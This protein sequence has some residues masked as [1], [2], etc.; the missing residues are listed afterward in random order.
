MYP[1]NNTQVEN[2]NIEE[3]K[4]DNILVCDGLVKLYKT[5]DVEVMALQGLE[6]EIERG[7]LVAII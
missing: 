1:E 4:K 2:E 6:L 5:K 3:V 7:E